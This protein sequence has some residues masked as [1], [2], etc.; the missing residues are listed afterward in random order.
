MPNDHDFDCECK[1]CMEE[2]EEGLDTMFPNVESK[3]ELE[4]ALEHEYSRMLDR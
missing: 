4:D 2:V 3:E 1:Q